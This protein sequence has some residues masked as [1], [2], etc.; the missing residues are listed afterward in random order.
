M[1]DLDKIADRTITTAI[2]KLESAWGGNGS[3][4]NGKT[5]VS[6]LGLVCF[7]IPL[8]LA[9][10][11]ADVVVDLE[12]GVIYETPSPD[13]PLTRGPITDDYRVLVNYLSYVLEFKKIPS[14]ILNHPV[15]VNML[16]SNYRNMSRNPWQWLR[17]H[18]GQVKNKYKFF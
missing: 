15:I 18:S 17:D 8:N 12:S 9:Q 7:P 4:L 1:M 10:T 16:N 11:P 5:P 3:Y 6:G 2:A 14:D 13:F